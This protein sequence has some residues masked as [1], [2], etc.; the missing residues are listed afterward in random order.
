MGSLKDNKWVN[1]VMHSD[2]SVI[3][4]AGKDRQ[5]IAT[6]LINKG[7][8][9]LCPVALVESA[10]SKKCYKRILTLQNL[11]KQDYLDLQGPVCI[12]VGEVL[13]DS[14][15]YEKL[16]KEMQSDLFAEQF[17]EIKKISYGK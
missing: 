5:R 17:S 3:Y 4:M 12:I 10:G 1:T 13:K 9:P 14:N 16:P 7:M 11:M 6:L 2:T 8:S 15:L